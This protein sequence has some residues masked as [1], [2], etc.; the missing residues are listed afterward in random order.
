M[1]TDTPSRIYADASTV[2][3]RAIIAAAVRRAS[4]TLMDPRYRPEEAVA[5]AAEELVKPPV[6]RAVTALGPHNVADS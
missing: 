1:S 4:R 5:A 2:A 6:V 3:R